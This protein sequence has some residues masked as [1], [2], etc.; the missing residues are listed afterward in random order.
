MKRHSM[1]GH[2]PSEGD[3]EVVFGKRIYSGKKPL[4]VDKAAEAVKERRRLAD[5]LRLRL[6]KLSPNGDAAAL[7]LASNWR[8]FVPPAKRLPARPTGTDESHDAELITELRL[9]RPAAKDRGVNGPMG[10]PHVTNLSAPLYDA[11]IKQGK[12]V[13]GEMEPAAIVAAA[14]DSYAAMSWFDHAT[15]AYLQFAIG[16][17]HRIV[18]LRHVALRL[19]SRISFA[20]HQGGRSPSSVLQDIQEASARRSSELQPLLLQYREELGLRAKLGVIGLGGYAK[21]QPSQ[22]GLLAFFDPEYEEAITEADLGMISPTDGLATLLLITSHYLAARY[23]AWVSKMVGAARGAAA[24]MVSRP[25]KR[26]ARM[27]AKAEQEY[28]DAEFA[29]PKMRHIKDVLCADLIS[30]SAEGQLA[31]WGQLVERLGS[32]LLQVHN[33]FSSDD[34]D[35]IESGAGMQQV[36]LAVELSPTLDKTDGFDLLGNGDGDGDGG[37]TQGGADSTALATAA[38]P[39]LTFGDMV[40]DQDGFDQAVKEAVEANVKAVGEQEEEHYHR[41]AELLR[42][43]PKLAQRPICIAAEIQLH[44]TYYYEMRMQSELPF[45]TKR[46]ST[47]RA[48]ASDCAPYKNA[49]L[50]KSSTGKLF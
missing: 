31:L 47:L 15:L 44:L 17:S 14:Q 11:P 43:L 28:D 48:L 2:T 10:Q 22:Q 5:A 8:E 35:S 3:Y 36:T 30:D 25:V 49:V 18:P 33:T 50:S 6:G 42:S 41:A 26:F 13:E 12:I 20:T 34:D 45:R 1:L 40:A 19:L 27:K 39:P 32:R 9:V 46:A 37:S 23:T 4:P 16:A 29:E 24:V 38:S 7:G 21:L